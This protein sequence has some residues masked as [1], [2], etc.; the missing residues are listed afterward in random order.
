[1]DLILINKFLSKDILIINLKIIL[2]RNEVLKDNLYDILL[3]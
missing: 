2:W 1:M 3:S